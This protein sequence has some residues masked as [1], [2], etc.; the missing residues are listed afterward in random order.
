MLRCLDTTFHTSTIMLPSLRPKL[1]PPFVLKTL[2]TIKL[3]PFLLI[4]LRQYITDFSSLAK[5]SVQF[6]S[7]ARKLLWKVWPCTDIQKS[8][9]FLIQ[10]FTVLFSSDFVSNS[11]V[12]RKYWWGNI[13]LLAITEWLILLRSISDSSQS[14]NGTP[15]VHLQPK[16]K[17]C[18][19]YDTLAF[20]F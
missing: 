16:S 9:L 10:P 20:K 12:E 8:G 4:T 3:S 11:R 7:L 5:T 18:W 19:W 13:G 14:F 17:G 2:E 1:N 6:F 15:S